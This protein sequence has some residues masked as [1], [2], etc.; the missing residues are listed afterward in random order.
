MLD[1]PLR[2]TCCGWARG[3]ARRGGHGNRL[4]RHAPRRTARAHGGLCLPLRRCGSRPAERAD[5][6]GAL[7]RPRADRRRVRRRSA[8]V[9]RASLRAGRLGRRHRLPCG[10]DP[11]AG[12]DCARRWQGAHRRGRT[13]GRR[14]RGSVRTPRV[15]RHRI[16]R[17]ALDASGACHRLGG[18]R[19][20]HCRP[21]A[22]PGCARCARVRG[23]TGARRR[24]A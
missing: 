11:C 7:V 5:R 23:R 10:R 20:H 4:P 19:A 17:V 24:H 3:R 22:A 1:V 16:A 9:G 21:S 13:V 6:G 8:G 14:R 18:T 2:D 12:D 15:H